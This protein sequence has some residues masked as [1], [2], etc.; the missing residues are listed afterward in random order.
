MSQRALAVGITIAAVLLAAAP[1]EARA[2]GPAASWS[3]AGSPVKK[4]TQTRAVFLKGKV[5]VPGG[6]DSPQF[7]S[8]LHK[9]QILATSR[10]KW[11]LD[12]ESMPIG[13]A[14]AAVCTDGSRVFA[15]GG[16]TEQGALQSSMQIYDPAAP[17]G[18]RWSSGPPPMTPADGFLFIRDGG[19]AWLD[20]KLYLFGGQGQSSNGTIDGITDLTWAFDPGT[21]T[22][23]DTGLAMKTA[24][25][26]FGYASKGKSAFV[27]GGR[28]ADS[29]TLRTVEMFKPASGWSLRAKLPNPPGAPAGTGLEWPGVGFLASQLAVFGGVAAGGSAPYQQRTLVCTLPCDP[30]SSWTN[31]HKDLI[32]PRGELASASGGPIPTLYAVCGGNQQGFV[33]TAEKTT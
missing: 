20:G 17:S 18:S 30:T 31:A 15:I 25:W 5:Y 24:T 2:V 10:N 28:D 21:Q 11:T 13:V 22:W 8:T 16:I 29:N 27:A 7:D 19:C 14:Q 12:G 3:P 23:S 32:T 6:W 1:A 4:V 9:M 26:V 33:A